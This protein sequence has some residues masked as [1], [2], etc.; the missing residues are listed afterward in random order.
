MHYVVASW[1]DVSNDKAEPVSVP[2][3]IHMHQA[4]LVRQ[5]DFQA[6]VCADLHLTLAQKPVVIQLRPLRS[7]IHSLCSV[8]GSPSR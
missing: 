1:P 4:K 2:R 8:A 6:V 7:G 3:G 5:C